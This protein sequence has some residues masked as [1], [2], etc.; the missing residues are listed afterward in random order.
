MARPSRGPRH[1][2]AQPWIMY[3]PVCRGDV[4]VTPSNQ[5]D[6]DQSHNYQCR[7]CD[8][9]FEINLLDRVRDNDPFDAP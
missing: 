7:T 6:V 5:Y 2:V 8:R 3:C 4:G 9:I 1:G